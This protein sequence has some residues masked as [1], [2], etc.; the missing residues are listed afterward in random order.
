MTPVIRTEALVKYYGRRPL[1]NGFQAG[2]SVVLLAAS[3]VLLGIALVG[4]Q[5]R[6]V[7]V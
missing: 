2:D 4:F 6:D 7:A 3:L 1:L 5:R